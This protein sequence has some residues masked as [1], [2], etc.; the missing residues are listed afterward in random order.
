[1]LTDHKTIFFT[2]VI[3]FLSDDRLL[4]IEDMTDRI[5]SYSSFA[6]TKDSEFKRMFDY[7]LMK[8]MQAGLIPTIVS[9]YMRDGKPEPGR[10]W[11][12]YFF[13]GTR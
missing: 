12:V 4:V 13:L 2:N 10:A 9:K 5:A 1:M 7:H 11:Q 6:L 8:S 3:P